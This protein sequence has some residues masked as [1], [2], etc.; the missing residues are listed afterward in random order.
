MLPAIGIGLG[1]AGAI[2]KIGARARANRDLKRLMKEDPVYTENPLAR[3]RLGLAQTLLNSRMPGSIAAER[4]I[5]QSGANAMGQVSRNATDSATAL[6]LAGSLQG[7][8]NDAFANLSQLEAA[9]YQRRYQNYE[10]AQE[11]V[12]REGDKVFQD[13]ARRFSNKVGIQGQINQNRQNAWGE[14]SN[15]GMGLASFGLNGGDD[16]LSEMRSDRQDNIFNSY[17]PARRT[18]SV[19]IR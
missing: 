12:I 17:A 5:Y 11:G 13:Q 15:F 6:S 18:S 8:T 4:N 7:Q 2:G 9:D 14:I 3:Q 19:K 10:G 16:A 1:V